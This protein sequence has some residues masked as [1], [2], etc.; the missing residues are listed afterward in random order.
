VSGYFVAT[1]SNRSLVDPTDPNSG[2]CGE[3]PE[4]AMHLIRN[5]YPGKSDLPWTG[6]VFG[7]SISSLWYWCSDQVRQ[8]SP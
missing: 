2:Y 5:P 6:M 7:L 1:A 8:P 3:P 4:D